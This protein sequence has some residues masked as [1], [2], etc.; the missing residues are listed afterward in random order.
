MKA[1]A[2]SGFGGPEVLEWTE[3]PDPPVGPDTVLVRTTAASVNPVDG[4]VREGTLKDYFPH[5]FPIVPGWDLSGVV[6]RVGTAVTEYAAGDRVVGYVRRDD[7]QHGTYAELVPA[8]VRTLAKAPRDTG[9]AT[10]AGLPLAGLTAW[11]AL[12]AVRVGPGDTVLVN[13][14]SGGVGTF[15]VQLAGILGARV[16][17]TAGETSA[18]LVRSLGAE[19]VA[20]GDGL[21]DRVQQLAPDGVDALVDFHGSALAEAA[22]LVSDASRV[23]SVVDAKTVGEL[24]GRYVFVRPDA[25]DLAELV[26]FVD[27]G[28]LRIVVD[29]TLPVQEAAQAQQLSQDGHLH[30]KLI[31]TVAS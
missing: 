26:G 19:P 15:A 22:A 6:E 13:G 25:A 16:L 8:P 1:I 18:D 27:D 29:R 10:A 28:R 11:Q 4:V 17:G 20:Y 23:A 7:V 21:V 14:A 2:Y 12:R 3:L 31:L 5:R 30:G 24:G 9:L